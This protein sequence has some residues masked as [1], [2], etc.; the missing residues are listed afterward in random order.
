MQFLIFGYCLQCA[1]TAIYV[2]AGIVNRTDY[3]LCALLFGIAALYSYPTKNL[4]SHHSFLLGKLSSGLR[5]R[6]VSSRR[7][8]KCTCRLSSLSA[9]IQTSSTKYSQNKVKYILLLQLLLF[10]HV[11][12]VEI[13][14]GMLKKCL[15]KEVPLLKL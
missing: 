12:I 13:T 8:L 3:S 15:P 2:K 4:L 10:Y 5:L 7:T 11:T 9:Q 6:L 14:H 1:Y